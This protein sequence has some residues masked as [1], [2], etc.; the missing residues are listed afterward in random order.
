MCGAIGTGYR[1]YIAIGDSQTEGLWDGDDAVGLLGFA[2][3]LAVL[4]D[5]FFPGLRYA[6]LA[7]RGKRMADVLSEQVPQALAMRPDLITVC[8]GM[9]DV[10]Q[11][12]RSFGRALVDL[13]HVHAALADS[14]ATVVTTTFPNVAQFLPLGRLVSSRLTRI[15]DAIAAA[16]DRYGFRLVDLYN[17][18]SMHNVDTWAVDRVHAS[19]QGHILFAAAA[20]EALKLPDSNHDWAEASGHPMRLSFPASAYEQLRW[21]HDSFIPW[22]WRRLRGRSSADGRVPKRPRLEPLGAPR[23]SGD[24]TARFDRRSGILDP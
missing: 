17:A 15:N 18:P 1:R 10:I 14:G 11:P 9:N 24:V 23:E 5:S 6:N 20:A 8:A 21:T 16:A 4:I 22:I 2:D 7:I 12:G 3:R 19:S 13:D